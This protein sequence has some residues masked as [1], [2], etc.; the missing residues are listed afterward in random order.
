MTTG[1]TEEEAVREFELE[2][3]V[4]GRRMWGTRVH[5]DGQTEEASNG[6]WQFLVQLD[7]AELSALRELVESS[8]FFE[9]PE[10]I[11]PEIPVADG[12]MLSWT[13]ALGDRRHSVSALNVTS[14]EH[15]VLAKLDEELQR[16]V[17]EALNREADEEEEE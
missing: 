2:Y 15:A 3:V 12:S 11:E 17:G 6:E 9:L 1:E 5:G 10:E 7:M 4:R 8:G 13:V 16:V 14:R